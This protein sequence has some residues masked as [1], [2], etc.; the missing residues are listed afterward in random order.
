MTG[1]WIAAAEERD[2]LRDREAQLKAQLAQQ[3][4]MVHSLFRFLWDEDLL[5]RYEAWKAA[6]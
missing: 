3:Q 6:R 4:Q 2:K 5:D 1:S